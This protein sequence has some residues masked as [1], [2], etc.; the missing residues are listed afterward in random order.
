ML[1]WYGI[2]RE[3]WQCL[4]Y[5]SRSIGDEFDNAMEC[6]LNAENRVQLI[7]RNITQKSNILKFKKIICSSLKDKTRKAM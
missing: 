5:N 1:R 6:Q 2:E 7:S 3:N 4:K